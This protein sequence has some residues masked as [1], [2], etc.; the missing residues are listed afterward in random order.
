MAKT[1]KKKPSKSA[2]EDR[3]KYILD[4]DTPT[5]ITLYV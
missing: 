2:L 3:F 5:I 4:I 1:T